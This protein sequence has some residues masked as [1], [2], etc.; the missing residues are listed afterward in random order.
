ML[1]GNDMKAKIGQDVT[2]ANAASK[3]IVINTSPSSSGTLSISGTQTEKVGIPFPIAATPYDAYVFSGWTSAG[4]GNVTF[5]DATAAKVNAKIGT[6]ADN[7]VITANFTVRPTVSSTSP[8]NNRMGVGT[9]SSIQ[10]IFATSLKT[11]TIVMSNVKV[12]TI[13]QGLVGTSTPTDITSSFTITPV[14]P[15]GASSPTGFILKDAGGMS[16][17][18]LVTVTISK[19]ISDTNGN[20]MASDYTFQFYTGNGAVAVP[21]IS[22]VSFSR[23]LSGAPGLSADGGFNGALFVKPTVGIDSSSDQSIKRLRVIFTDVNSSGIALSIPNIETDEMDFNGAYNTITPT[24]THA[25]GY[26]QAEIQVEDNYSQWSATNPNYDSLILIYDKTRPNAPT[27]ANNLNG[28]LNSGIYYYTSSGVTFSPNA[29]DP[30]SPTSGAAGSLIAGYTTDP[31]G[32]SPPPSISL[33][34]TTS[35]TIYAVDNAGNVS[36][37]GLSLALAQDSVMPTISSVTPTSG[38]YYPATAGSTG[39][40]YFTKSSI[41]F[42]PVY[43]VG[44]SGFA[45]FTTSPTGTPSSAATTI[46]LSPSG[47]VQTI[48]A[49]NNLGAHSVA[50]SVTVTNDTAPAKPAVA[51]P[52]GAYYDS[53]ISTYFTTGASL[54]FSPTSTDT[55]GS[56]IVGFSLDGS[57]TTTVAVGG[58]VTVTSGTPK[59]I[60]AVNHLNQVS[61]GLTVTVTTDTAPAKP[62]VATPTGAYYDS[63]T[64]AYFATGSSLTFSPTSTDT[65]GSG[66]VG[67]SLDGSSTTTVAVGGTVTVTSGTP[68]TIYAVNHSNQVSTGL[69]VTVTTDTAPA[70]PAVATPTG[71]YY[72]SGTLAYFTTGASLAF[73]PTSTDTGGSGVAGFSLDGSGTITVAVGGTVTVASGSPKTIYA[74]NHVGQVSTA[75]AVTVTTDTAPATPAVA[76]PT[77]AYYDSGTSTYF[78]T[79]ASL[80]FSPT[81]TDTGGSGVVGFSLDGSSTTTVAVGGAVTVTSGTPRTIYAVN[82]SNQVSTGLTVTVKTDTAPAKPAVATPTG[83]YYDSGTSTY[84][85]TGASLAFSPT[86]TDTGG[87]GVVGFSLDGTSTT[88]VAVGGTV[89]VASG[90]PKTIYAVNHLNQ[91]STGL[92]VTMTTDAAPVILATGQ[93]LTSGSLAATFTATNSSGVTAVNYWYGTT[94]TGTGTQDNLGTVT[95]A[96]NKT[97]S[98]TATG[99][100]INTT[101]PYFSF[102]LT[103]AAGATSSSSTIPITSGSGSKSLTINPSASH[104]VAR[105]TSSPR[106]S[107]TA[108]SVPITFVDHPAA[109]AEG[110]SDASANDSSVALKPV[111]ASYTEPAKPRASTIDSSGLSLLRRSAMAA[112][113]AAAAAKVADAEVPATEVRYAG[114]PESATRAAETSAETSAAASPAASTPTPAAPTAPAPQSASAAPIQARASAPTPA[115]ESQ[116]LPKGPSAPSRAPLP[117]TDIYVNQSGDR[118]EEFADLCDEGEGSDIL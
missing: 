95:I 41:T 101:D 106:A 87:S 79:G 68:K 5:D 97:G 27:S 34:L 96:N 26:V 115:A 36:T 55:G 74:V 12:T 51:T 78:T 77:G 28:F 103:D 60:Y 19:A 23:Y 90:T 44:V 75:L 57:S 93:T 46:S 58:T 1:T 21:S 114:A 69:T 67:F 83:A 100:T 49:V 85:A 11:S 52:T 63:G 48:Y 9:N 3:Q 113:K 70:K 6:A 4:S 31:A 108:P 62:A 89:T 17:V 18:Q 112:A 32:V 73:S 81:S 10:V 40:T 15:T 14:T 8:F 92:A 22:A 118:R 37:S 72:D 109:A 98:L 71:S 102:T 80:I 47:S 94:P 33:T 20:T 45:G 64:S 25:E 76:T 116:P 35:A 38:T 53:G 117:K 59:T 54:T 88:T 29:S 2:A 111:E 99:I 82:H 39:S 84:F 24:G 66:V 61:T 86:S 30:N 50:F 42:T 104:P 13:S 107:Y 91:V 110:A 56:G 65:G 7:I 43:S 16:I 105:V